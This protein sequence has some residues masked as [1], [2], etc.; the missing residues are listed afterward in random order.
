MVMGAVSKVAR[1][2]VRV[3]CSGIKSLTAPDDNYSMDTAVITA[4]VCK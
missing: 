2:N 4:L 1:L 3:T